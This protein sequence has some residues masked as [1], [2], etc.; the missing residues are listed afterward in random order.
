MRPTGLNNSV[1]PRPEA[2]TR[3]IME[4]AARTTNVS[5]VYTHTKKTPQSP[6]QNM[7]KAPFIC[8][9]TMTIL[10]K[11]LGESVLIRKLFQALSLLEGGFE[12]VDNSSSSPSQPLIM[13]IKYYT[14]QISNMPELSLSRTG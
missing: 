13:I 4:S 5:R 14:N 3:K 11:N 6:A 9:K 2:K 1:H 12:C 8:Y 10:K 7:M